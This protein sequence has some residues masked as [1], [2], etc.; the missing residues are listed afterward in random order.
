[1]E[2]GQFLKPG[3]IIQAR[4]GSL[5]PNK[6]L[7]PLP[8][9]SKKTIISEIVENLKYISDVSNIIVATSTSKVNNDLENILIV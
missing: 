8:V 3:F 1:M 7:L 4:L 2:V 6:V 9:G 5:L